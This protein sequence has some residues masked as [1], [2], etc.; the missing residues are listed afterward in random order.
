MAVAVGISYFACTST[1]MLS[2]SELLAIAKRKLENGIQDSGHSS[3]T[4]ASQI[5]CNSSAHNRIFLWLTS[6]DSIKVEQKNEQ[7]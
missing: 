6:N 4:L 3:T 1:L 2:V 7:R 5:R